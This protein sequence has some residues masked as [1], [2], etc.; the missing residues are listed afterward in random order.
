MIGT[1][2][3]A[4]V[5]LVAALFLSLATISI[6][7]LLAIAISGPHLLEQQLGRVWFQNDPFSSLVN[8]ASLPLVGAVVERRLHPIL[9]DP[10]ALYVLG[11]PAWG[12]LLLLFAVFGVIGLALWWLPRRR[13]AKL[14][15]SEVA[16]V[17]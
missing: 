3:R 5:R 8:T 12:A 1:V 4:L 7:F 17:V 15:N 10:I 6:G 11:L 14:T 9:W 2:V 16:D 13:T